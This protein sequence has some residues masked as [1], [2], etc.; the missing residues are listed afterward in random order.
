MI[1]RDVYLQKIRKIKDQHIIKVITGIRRSGKST[2]LEIFKNELLEASVP[3]ENIIFINFEERENISYSSWT[4]LY[5]E[6]ISKMD[7]TAMYYIFLDEVQLIDDFEKLVNSLFT[8]KNVD[9]YVTGSNAYL[10]SSELATLLT[11]R[12]IAINIQP[13]S[14][15]EYMLS[16]TDEANKDRLFHQYLNDSCFPEAVN[17][18]K[19]SEELVNDYLQSIYDTVI[20][21]DIAQRHKLRNINNLHRIVSFLF[22]S[23]GSYISATNIA[24]QLNKNSQ[25]SISHNTI[26]KYL[27]FLTQS[28][29]LYKVP[30]Y[31]LKGKELLSTHEKYYVVD[32][33]L[34]NITT[35]NHQHTDLGHKLENVIYFELLRRGGK[36]YVGKHKN[37][38]IDFVVQKPN[39]Q[40]E[41]YQVAYTV[42]SEKT[43]NREMSVFNTLKD[44]Y[45]K[46][47]LTLDY[48]NETINGVKKLN[49]VD[50]LLAD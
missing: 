18:S 37:N 10:L 6:I 23:I 42:N 24:T 9:L 47:L 33:G 27:D 5:D 46:Y 44:H 36:V 14:F 43:F 39:N 30:R 48:G 19:V 13:Y 15:K 11:G 41:Y 20:I 8:K 50:W 4:V 38:E 21:K 12:Y 25:K 7:N 3:S 26:L 1:N 28:Y 32:L 29:I 40:R 34:R 45:P 16:H 22:D 49:V 35:T 2:L 17:L 31:D